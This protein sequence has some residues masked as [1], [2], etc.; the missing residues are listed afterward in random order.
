MKGTRRITA[1][2]AGWLLAGLLGGAGCDGQTPDTIGT[3]ED[4]GRDTDTLVTDPIDGFGN[5]D[6]DYDGTPIPNPFEGLPALENTDPAYTP[7]HAARSLPDEGTQI[8][9]LDKALG[10]VGYANA[11]ALGAQLRAHGM[12]RQPAISYGDLMSDALVGMAKSLNGP[13][14]LLTSDA[15]FSTFH[16]FFDNALLGVESRVLIPRLGPML[17]AVKVEAAKRYNS[18][19]AGPTRQAALDVVAFLQVAESLL[20]P[21]A[22]VVGE[23]KDDAL[24]EISLIEAH[25]GYAASPILDRPGVSDPS[26]HGGVCAQCDPCKDC[27]WT[28]GDTVVPCPERYCEDYSQYVPRGHYTYS[29][30]LERYFRAVMWLGRMTLLNRSDQSTR[31]AVVLLDSLKSAKADLPGGPQPALAVWRQ[32]IMVVGIF[33]GSA[34]DLNAAE[35]DSAILAATGGDLSLDELDEGTTLAAIHAA[36]DGLRDPQILS[37]YLQALAEEIENTKGLRL[38]GQVFLPDSYVLRRLVYRNVGASASAAGWP[39]AADACDIASATDPETLDAV[40]THCVC[41]YA[42]SGPVRTWDVCRGMPSGLDVAAALGSSR[43]D[44]KARGLA[45]SYAWYGEGLDALRSEISGFGADRWGLSIAWTWIHAI[46]GL[47]A[48]LPPGMPPFMRADAWPDKNLETGLSA[49][50]QMRHDTIL[51]AEQSST[52][53]DSDGDSDGD[54][55][56]DVDYSFDYVE[57]RPE[58]YARMAAA[59]RRLSEVGTAEGLFAGDASPVASY[60]DRLAGEMERA[61]KISVEEIED[62]AL[63]PDET[64]YI[65]SSG[66]R[67]ADLENNL[68]VTLGIVKDGEV[69]DPS[70]L[71]TTIIADVHTFGAKSAVLEVGTGYLENVAVVQRLPGGQWGVAVGPALSYHEFEQDMDSRLTDEQWRAIVVAD[72]SYGHPSWLP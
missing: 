25:E 24:A 33:V 9:E 58:A 31:A 42:W 46:R 13:D 62:V 22:S 30:E 65:H 34:D 5:S 10:Y 47:L 17:R 71:K 4:A 7:A 14:V 66:Y 43:A 1:L 56:T 55:D 18:L 61:A 15:L 39:G 26:S 20:D 37:G 63:G 49:W 40:D 8:L 50:A 2:W 45:D 48:D 72:H 28:E 36:I 29:V 21:S 64:A 60:L 53:S 35:V 19:P 57:P 59:A 16:N 69:P 12:A 68:L 51:Y 54:G 6:L 38:A 52:D 41:A 3:D 67:L 11:Q 23:V 44:A 32:L 27:N 70:R